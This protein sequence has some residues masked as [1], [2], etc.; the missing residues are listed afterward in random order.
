[1]SRV[2]LTNTHRTSRRRDGSYVPLSVKG[3]PS[4]P[5]RPPLLVS[6]VRSF[7]PGERV[8]LVSRNLIA[9][10]HNSLLYRSTCP[11]DMKRD[12]RRGSLPNR[13][14]LKILWAQ[15]TIWILTKRAVRRSSRNFPLS[16][17][18]RFIRNF[19]ESSFPAV[20][21]RFRFSEIERVNVP[22]NVRFLSLLIKT[23]KKLHFDRCKLTVYRV[24]LDLPLNPHVTYS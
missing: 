10:I 9:D 19:V 12:T 3:L 18:A 5:S 6:F 4:R 8:T 2:T 13:L 11:R 24:L 23:I 20:E 1:M 7:L 22:G 21:R 15:G 17:N 16:R 14:V